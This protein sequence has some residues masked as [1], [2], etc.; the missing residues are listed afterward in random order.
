MSTSGSTNFNQTRNEIVTDALTGLG[1]LRPGGTA[2][3]ND[4]NY[5]SN[6]LNKIV[7]SWEGQGIHMWKEAEG[8]LFLLTNVNTYTIAGTGNVAGIDVVETTLTA[9]ASTTSLTVTSTTGMTAADQIGIELD[10]GT[11]QWTTIVSVDSSTGLTITASVSSAA[12]SGNTIFTYTTAV[13][14]PMHISS[15]RFRNTDGTDRMVFLKG[16]DEFMQIP[17]KTTTGKI[18]QAFYTPGLTSGTIYVWPTPDAVSDR[19][20]FSY[21]KLIEDFDAAGDNPDFPTEWLLTLTKSLMYCIARTYGKT[22]QDIMQLKQ[23]ADQSLIEMQLWDAGQGSLR[24]V[25]N[26]RDDDTM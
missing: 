15:A 11:R 13:S 5:C 10:D 8:T 26:Y 18:N 9:A 19:L 7:K 6:W 1:V 23:E 16:R 25:P 14:K 22:N 12:S 2:T 4:I 24:V 17:N 21:V 20:K 3:T